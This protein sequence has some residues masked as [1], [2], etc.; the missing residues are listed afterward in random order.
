METQCITAPTVR[1]CA[2]DFNTIAEGAAKT[3]KAGSV[4]ASIID[5]LHRHQNNIPSFYLL[6]TVLAP[7]ETIGITNFQLIGTILNVIAI[8]I[9]LLLIYL[10]A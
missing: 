8:N 9:S 4:D 5:Y 2:W 1:L 6:K 7:A 10:T 3:V